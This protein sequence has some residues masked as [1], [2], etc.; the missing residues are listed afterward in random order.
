[1][2]GDGPRPNVSFYTMRD[3]KGK[4]SSVRLLGTVPGKS[5]NHIFWSPQGKNIVLAGLK[6]LNG[7]LG[8][9]GVGGEGGRGDAVVR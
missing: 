2:H 3:D 4:Q 8:E 1:M 9:D 7:Q 6:G 5:C